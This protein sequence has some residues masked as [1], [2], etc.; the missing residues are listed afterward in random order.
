MSFDSEE[1]FEQWKAGKTWPSFYK[2]YLDH[3]MKWF[4][5]EVAKK[6]TGQFGRKLALPSESASIDAAE[7]PSVS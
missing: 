7:T 1:Q 3:P 2:K 6:E 5:K 4:Q